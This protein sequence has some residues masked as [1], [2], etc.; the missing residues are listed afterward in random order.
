MT[1]HV[2]AVQGIAG[3]GIVNAVEV[4]R[5]FP[6]LEGMRQFRDWVLSPDE[7]LVEALR[8]RKGNTEEASAPVEMP[9]E[10][11]VTRGRM[12]VMVTP[13]FETR[14]G[15]HGAQQC[16]HFRFEMPCLQF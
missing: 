6:G 8:G 3:I 2:C 9:G 1:A 11:G 14:E 7:G 5:A 12:S 16:F 4:V 10:T 13:S 15:L